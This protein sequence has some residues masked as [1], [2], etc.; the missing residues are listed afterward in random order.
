[1]KLGLQ[2][3]YEN[4]NYTGKILKAPALLWCNPNFYKTILPRSDP[5]PPCGCDLVGHKLPP[6][7]SAKRAQPSPAR[8]L[9]PN[10]SPHL[11]FSDACPNQQ[12][13]SFDNTQPVKICLGCKAMK[14]ATLINRLSLLI[15]FFLWSFTRGLCMLRMGYCRPGYFAIRLGS[16]SP[17]FGASPGVVAPLCLL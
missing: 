15:F 11:A 6:C 2:S 17:Q 10:C 12:N 8:V 9:P 4:I 3:S 14:F 13:D 16:E 5:G 1:M 7:P